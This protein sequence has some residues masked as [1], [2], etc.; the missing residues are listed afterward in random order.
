MSLS[1]RYFAFLI[2][3]W[4]AAST[5]HGEDNPSIG[6]IAPLNEKVAWM[7]GDLGNPVSLEVT[8]MTPIGPG[9]FPL[10]V[11]NHG[12]GS[13]GEATTTR[14]HVSYSA[15]YFL[16][17]G[18]AVALP[19]MRGFG[20]SDGRIDVH[21][22]R[23]EEVGLSSARDIRAVIDHITATEPAIDTTRVVMAGQ[24]YGG[25]NTLAFGTLRFPRVVGLINFAGGVASPQCKDWTSQLPRSAA[26]FGARTKTPS[27]WLYGDNDSIFPPSIWRAMYDR[28]TKAGGP[29]E[30]VAYGNF[31]A[32]SHNMLGFMEG[33]PI[34][35]PKVDGFLARLGM[36]Y[37]NIYPE[38][39]PTEFPPPS[40]FATVDDID[41]VPNL[42]TEGKTVY[43]TFLRATMPR[44]FVLSPSGFVGE[45]HG[46]ADPVG[47]GLTSCRK[48]FND[49]QVYAADNDVTWI[50]P[51]PV[52]APPP[53]HFAALDD[54]DAV[55][56][57]NDQGKKT[58]RKYLQDPLPRAFV[59]APS[60]MFG[61]FTGGFDPIARGLSACGQRAKGCRVYAVNND[62]TW[63][64]PTPAP[65]ATHFAAL[66][67]ERAVPYVT[68]GGRQGY[69]KFL[70]FG[71][72]RAFV[73]APDGAWSASRGGDDPVATAM[74]ACE[75]EHQRCRLY[76]VDN[77]IVWP[78]AQ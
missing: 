15:Y 34:W 24:S 48:R 33:L 61:S 19:M 14:Y 59:V 52:Q 65:P 47:R 45:F 18:Y 77:D 40:H 29:A 11:M 5:V 17:R 72:P 35:T 10:A 51:V 38:Y 78:E 43:K 50:P 76:A 2:L 55:P 9:P 26:S 44:V 46:G 66:T 12:A 20:E 30:L 32:D 8:V 42:S 56:Y 25:W 27:I 6:P 75:K 3:V 23:L 16:S 36:P 70:A 63:T 13:V 39:L 74:Q 4:G 22:C 58:Y 57:L 28:Y 7:P 37:K 41:A 31:M 21:G 53:S 49:C 71:I 54:V 64:R 69:L 60:G 68:D 73:I 62:V 1:Q 67:D